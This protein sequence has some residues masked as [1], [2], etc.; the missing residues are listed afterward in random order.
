MSEVNQV[1]ERSEEE[2]VVP[3]VEE[4]K[5]ER[6]WI[7]ALRRARILSRASTRADSERAGILDLVGRANEGSTKRKRQ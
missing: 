4:T 1:E 3:H 7:G 5:A 6:N 2:E